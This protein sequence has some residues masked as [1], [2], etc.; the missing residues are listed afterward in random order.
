M[1]DHAI[2][3][4]LRQILDFCQP[5]LVKLEVILLQA[6]VDGLD[7]IVDDPN[8]EFRVVAVKRAQEYGQQVYIAVLDLPWP[9]EDF[10]EDRN[11]L[12]RC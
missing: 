11:H 10:F 8:D 12:Q 3:V 5:T 4:Q 9:R 6:E 1:L 7:H 2:V